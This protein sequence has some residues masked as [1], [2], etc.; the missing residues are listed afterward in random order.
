MSCDHNIYVL[1]HTTTEIEMDTTDQ[2][3]SHYSHERNE[4]FKTIEIYF[5]NYIMRQEIY[6]LKSTISSVK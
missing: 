2:N 1:T 5:Y 4:N 3:I 6:T